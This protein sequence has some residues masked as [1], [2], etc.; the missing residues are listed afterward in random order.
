MFARVSVVG[1]GMISVDLIANRFFVEEV[2]PPPVGWYIS[3]CHI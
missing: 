2:L 1:T 3:N